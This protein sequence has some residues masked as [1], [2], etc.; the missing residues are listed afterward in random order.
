MIVHCP[1][2]CLLFDNGLFF[3]LF[4]VYCFLLINLKL[5]NG[6]VSPFVLWFFLFGIPNS[7]WISFRS[8]SYRLVIWPWNIYDVYTTYRFVFV[9]L[10]FISLCVLWKIT[11]QNIKHTHTTLHRLTRIITRVKLKE[12]HLKILD[13]EIDPNNK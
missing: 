11:Y 13:N 4:S 5:Y 9:I 1:S 12:I 3:A 2:H 6:F 10:F 7:E 8:F